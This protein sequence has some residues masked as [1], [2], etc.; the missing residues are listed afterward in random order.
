MLF[1]NLFTVPTGQKVTERHLTRVLVASICSILLCMG[2]LV[3][4]TWAW[5]TLSIENTGNEIWIGEPK[6]HLTIDGEAYVSG[7]EPSG[8]NVQ[9]TMTHANESD[10][11]DKKSTLYVTLNVHC[12][13]ETTS[14]YVILN[15]VNGYS[16]LVNI[17]ND[18]GASYSVTWTVSWFA[19][20]NATAWDGNPIVLDGQEPIALPAD[21]TETGTEP[22]EAVTEPTETVTEPVVEG[23]NEP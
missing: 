19:P 11:F 14:V 22:T 15:E 9:L 3:S 10:D 12:G 23:E 4:T 16:A 21:P 5:F 6:I 8:S 13:E 2:C 17:Q 7:T 18:T 1:K 20:P